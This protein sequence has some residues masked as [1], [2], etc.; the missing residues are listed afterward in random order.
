MKNLCDVCVILPSDNMQIIEDFHL[1]V[2]HA[3][4][5]VIRQRISETVL[6]KPSAAGAWAD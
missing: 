3:V 5:S 6:A 2:T 1:S 4:F